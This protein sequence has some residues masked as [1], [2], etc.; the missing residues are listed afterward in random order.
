MVSF[1]LA[2]RIADKEQAMKLRD[3]EVDAVLLLPAETQV[4]IPPS[5]DFFSFGMDQLLCRPGIRN[6]RHGGRHFASC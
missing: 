2:I 1:F 6:F 5:G 4:H 3:V